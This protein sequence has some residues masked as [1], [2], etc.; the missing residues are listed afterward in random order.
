MKIFHV[1]LK[2]DGGSSRHYYFSSLAAIYE[3]LR[4]DDIGCKVER[5]WNFGVAIDHP[6]ENKHCIIRMGEVVRKK[7]QAE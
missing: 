3:V 2:K 5:L 7:R 1:E 6:F 4:V